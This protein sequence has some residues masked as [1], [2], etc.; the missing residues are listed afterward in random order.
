MARPVTTPNPIVYLPCE[1]KGRD[2]DA[3]LLLAARLLERGLAVVFGQQWSIWHNAVNAPAGVVVMTSGSTVHALAAQ[4]FKEA[5]NL[6]M[7]MDEEA[8]ALTSS[9]HVRANVCPAIAPHV[10]V[11]LAQSEQH[12]KWMANPYSTRT[13]VVGNPRFDLLTEQAAKVYEREVEMIQ[14]GGPYVLFNANFALAHYVWGDIKAMDPEALKKNGIRIEMLDWELENLRVFHQMIRLVMRELPE[15]RIIIR[16]HPA[17]DLKPWKEVEVWSA[18]I[19]CI[20]HSMP[21]EFM[22]GADFVVHCNCTT[23]LEAEMLGRP[24][25]NLSPDPKSEWARAFIMQNVNYSPLDPEQTVPCVRTGKFPVYSGN[26]A[27]IQE[28]AP[29]WDLGIAS[30]RIADL[31]RQKVNPDGAGTPFADMTW[32]RPDRPEGTIYKFVSTRHDIEKRLTMIAKGF[33]ISLKIGTR[34]LDDSVL[35]MVPQ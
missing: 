18:K 14:S 21:I 12:A 30:D 7:L 28:H 20:P 34:Q 4:R 31:I 3:K 32:E 13:V 35:L 10:D 22:R 5:G 16:P 33:G 24:T 23:G 19:G 29:G 17:E 8:L 2:F 1:L 11:F 6:T 25:I 26:G 9:R 27:I 15:H